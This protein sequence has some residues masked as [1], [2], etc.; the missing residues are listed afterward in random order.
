M[1]IDVLSQF[2]IAQERACQAEER[3]RQ[4]EAVFGQNDPR[5]ERLGLTA[6]EGNIVGVIM[7]RPIASVSQ[8]H[9][10]IY[11]NRVDD[12]PDEKT[13]TVFIHK[14]RH[15][16]ERYG[17]HIECVWGRGYRM[18]E[19]SKAEIRSIIGA[20]RPQLE[21]KVSHGLTAHH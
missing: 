16:L 10:V 18:D 1:A 20:E 8:I 2:R 4:L 19:Q 9:T 6:T 5:Y 15:K 12:P 14:I 11:G 3:V 13:I 7:A 21:K 17:I